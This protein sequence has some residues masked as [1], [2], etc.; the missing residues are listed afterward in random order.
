M[1]LTDH[2]GWV[3]EVVELTDPDEVV[4]VVAGMVVG[5]TVSAMEVVGTT[6]MVVVV[7]GDA[8][9]NV[10]AATLS[11]E[12]GRSLTRSSAALTIC[13]VKEVVRTRTNDHAVMR[14]RRRIAAL[15]QHFA[16]GAVNEASRNP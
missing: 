16:F 3:V 2:S 14:P 11:G 12:T 15:S 5:V 6:G 7:V 13:H 1:D 4:V 8:G 9:A 10:G